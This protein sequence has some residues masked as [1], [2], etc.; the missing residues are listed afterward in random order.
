MSSN[1]IYYILYAVICSVLFMSTGYAKGTQDERH[2]EVALRMVGHQVL[3]NSGDSTSRVLPI[4]IEN[5]R[6]KIQFASEFEFIPGDLVSTVH[7]ILNESEIGASYILEV[8]QCNTGEVVYSYEMN[9]TEK[10]DIIP[11]V[12][13]IQPKSCY[14]FYLSL[15][16]SE[17]PVTT[18]D[19][20]S[21]PGDLFM[22]RSQIG[23]LMV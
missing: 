12:G 5:D 7:R 8:E 10:S 19:T 15:M 1:K 3:L 2:I 9:N 11:C 6:Y 23:Y 20:G 18:L 14:I 21:S 22:N 17:E 16:E 4:S 13:R